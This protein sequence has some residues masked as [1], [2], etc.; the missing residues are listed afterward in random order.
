MS[1]PPDLQA[2]TT[3][4][5]EVQA[6]EH[7]LIVDLNAINPSSK[8]REEWQNVT[9]T[10]SE[11]KLSTAANT[12]DSSFLKT[13]ERG[14]Y[15]A[16]FQCVCGIGARLPQKPT[17]DSTAR[18]GYYESDSN[19]NPENGFWFGADSQGVFVGRSH[20]G[21]VEKVYQDSWNRDKLGEGSLNPS[22]KTLNL[23]DGLVFRIDFTYYGYGPI[24][25]KI[26]IDD[27]DADQYGAA[28][29][30]TAHVFHVK[31]G[32]ST[33]NTNLPLQAE[34]DSGGT[35]NDALDFYIGGR[36]FSV[37][38]SETSNTRLVNHYRD[39]LTGVD[40]T[41]W[42]PAISYKIKDGSDNIGS[43]IDFSTVIGE[44]RRLAVDADANA[45]RWQ[46]RRDTEL[47]SPSWGIPSSHTDTPDETAF[48]VDTSATN[49]TDGSG[50]LTGVF[51]DGGSVD[52]G[53]KNI[54][55]IDDE[56]IDGQVTNG[57][58]VTLAFRA[59]PGSS[60]DLSEMYFKL[61]ENW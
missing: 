16:G 53:D 44:M 43:G 17:G 46:I 55:T 39:E 7:E 40:D 31:G 1:A 49:I 34:I 28:Q 41:Q 23:S 42:Y 59:T 26:L 45:Y 37:I 9:D 18:W 4:F 60:G 30:V 25:M 38:G 3:H 47:T 19:G 50:N 32:T 48:K 57:Q 52:E 36:Q 8:L 6:E 51:I 15:T 24:E 21:T 22:D 27:D 58:V 20:S 33:D 13:E 35:T 5:D 10:S 29:L 61:G 2:I 56:E 12:D 54:A 11:R 14:Q